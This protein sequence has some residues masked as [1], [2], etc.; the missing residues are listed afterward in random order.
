MIRLVQRGFKFL[1]VN[2][3]IPLKRYYATVQMLNTETDREYFQCI[4]FYSF[5]EVKYF[6]SFAGYQLKQGTTSDPINELEYPQEVTDARKATFTHI[7]K[8]K[9]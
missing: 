7:P 5:Q 6:A 2:Y 1:C 9:E 3:S 4:T 8:G